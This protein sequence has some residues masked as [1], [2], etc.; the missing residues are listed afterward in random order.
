[1]VSP[2]SALLFSIVLVLIAFPA[3]AVEVSVMVEQDGK[4]TEP[5]DVGRSINYNIALSGAA[6]SMQYTVSMQIGPD[7]S[8]PSVS[9]MQTGSTNLKPGSN[10]VIP[11]KVNFQSPEFRQGDFGQWLTDENETRFWDKAW[12]RIEVT[13]L[14]PFE[15]PVVI[16]DYSGRPSLVKVVEKFKDNEVSP[17]TGSKNDL[18]DYKVSVFSTLADNISLEIAPDQNG[19]WEPLEAKMYTTPGTWKTLV[20]SNVSLDFDFDVAYY[21]FVGRK[22]T[23]SF[24]GPF[25]PVV[26]EFKNS[27]VS[28]ERGLANRPFSYSLMV[29]ASKNIE[30]ELNTWDIAAKRFQSQ[31]RMAY[32]NYSRW[33]EMTW[34]DVRPTSEAQLAGASNYYFSFY[35]TGST[36]PFKI[37]YEGASYYPGPELILVSFENATV[38]PD[39]GS[40]L[41]PYSYGINVSTALPKIDV[42]LQ[43]ADPGSDMWTSRGVVTYE[44][45][46]SLLTWR[47]IKLDG[48]SDGDARF[49]FIAGDSRSEVFNGPTI[50][51]RDGVR[52]RVEPENGTMYFTQ[53]LDGSIS[54]VYT[55]QYSL[56][57]NN[58]I[59]NDPVEIRLEV[60]DPVAS[61]WLSG[62]TKTYEP[63]KNILNYTVNLA[64]LTFKEPFLG[65]MNYRFV[66]NDR[67]LGEFHGPYI[68]VNIRNES[69]VEVGSKITYRTEVRSTLASVPVA[70]AYTKDNNI[71]S[72]SDTR[73]YSSGSQEWKLL[74][75]VEYP[76]YYAY[77]FEVLRK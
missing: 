57:M 71:W 76:R 59:G 12:Y 18:Y 24:E 55:Y 16:E 19:P 70:L 7:Y 63:G 10:S 4:T 22:Q 32:K 2:R 44:G 26:V 14:N 75:W 60:Y 42:E 33:E 56:E 37:S 9:K 8:N 31:G 36:T 58:E 77:E 65:M 43:T 28:P 73:I 66:A 6:N 69:A 1:M 51:S 49:R 68:D 11:L 50:A 67:V 72:L 74:E 54:R 62:G 46:S 39:N 35:Y 13:S 38:T 52:A 21:R 53:V 34:T 29:N 30:V 40:A 48:D 3:E 61:N 5:Y 27:S 15:K 47:D 17:R 41:V 23:T 20:W 64:R 25:W 45:P